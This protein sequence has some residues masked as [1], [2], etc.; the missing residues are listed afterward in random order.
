MKPAA[1]AAEPHTTMRE[2]SYAFI[3]AR[4]W[5]MVGTPAT[6]GCDTGGGERAGGGVGALG[7]GSAARSKA[8]GGT[9]AAACRCRRPPPCPSR[10]RGR[11]PPPPGSRPRDT[12][13]VRR[14]ELV[15]GGAAAPGGPLL[16]VELAALRA[17]H[18]LGLGHALRQPRGERVVVLD[19]LFAR[20][21]HPSHLL[22]LCEV[23]RAACQ[24]DA[25]AASALA[26]GRDGRST[27]AGM[28]VCR[29]R[30]LEDAPSRSARP[31]AAPGPVRR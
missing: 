16:G 26:P 23:R 7:V 30:T 18:G 31:L 20:R 17:S 25:H 6:I 14:A 28:H 15:H 12:H 29:L 21:S 4:A 13:V 3:P 8:N 27:F 11:L 5:P 24:R 1:A 19:Q 22:G 10:P 9:K 2:T